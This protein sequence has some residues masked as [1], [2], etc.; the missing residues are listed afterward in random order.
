V[1]EYFFRNLSLY[2]LSL[3]HVLDLNSDQE[4][5]YSVRLLKHN[6]GDSRAVIIYIVSRIKLNS[7]SLQIEDEV[8]K[9]YW[10]LRD[11]GGIGKEVTKRISVGH[12]A[13]GCVLKYETASG[14]DKN[15]GDSFTC[16]TQNS[17]ISFS[18]R[19]FRSMLSNPRS[20]TK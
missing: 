10:S 18:L 11:L 1:A 9:C 7:I 8:F 16:E 14:I 13:F 2:I 3:E 17:T 20:A 12:R 6:F 15:R 19:L 5:R 4:T